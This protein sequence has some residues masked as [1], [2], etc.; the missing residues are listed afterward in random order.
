MS[1]K[2]RKNG[3]DPAP[4]I[5]QAVGKLDAGIAHPPV[6]W[7]RVLILEALDHHEQHQQPLLDV[8]PLRKKT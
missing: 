3:F 1:W 8:Q 7:D 5:G 6:D 4:D 2:Q